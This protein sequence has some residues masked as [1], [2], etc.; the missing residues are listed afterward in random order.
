M[1]R[2]ARAAK[3]GFLTASGLVTVSPARPSWAN[4]AARPREA[5][6]MPQRASSSR[7]LSRVSGPKEWF[8][9]VQPHRVA[10]RFS[11][12]QLGNEARKIGQHV[13][14]GQGG[15]RVQDPALV[16]PAVNG[17]RAGLGIHH[18]DHADAT[19]EILSDLGVG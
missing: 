5:K 7:R 11:G 15:F 17:H 8:V 19:A 10:V 4:R 16:A 3:C 13:F 14:A 1:T 6:P 18:P 9:T 12:E 2:L